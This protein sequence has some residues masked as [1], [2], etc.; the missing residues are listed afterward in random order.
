MPFYANCWLVALV[1]RVVRG[2]T[3]Y[4]I[5]S[6]AFVKFADGRVFHFTPRHESRI[7]QWVERN[8]CLCLPFWPKRTLVILFLGR[9]Q[10]MKPRKVSLLFSLSKP[11]KVF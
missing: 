11:R 3:L 6:H 4:S 10:E 7:L 2:G 1:M 8:I 9:I 5:D